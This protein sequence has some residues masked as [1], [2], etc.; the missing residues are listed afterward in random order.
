MTSLVAGCMACELVS[1]R[2][3]QPGGTI[4]EDA[5]WHVDTA[6]SANVW[7]GFLMIK[8]K[9]H[10]VH[11]AELTAPEAASLGSVI[12]VTNRA[13]MEVLQP[14]K[15]YVCSFGDGNAHIHLWVL[16]RPA[17]MKAG[18]HPVIFNL[19]MRIF[20]TRVLHLKKWLV[21]EARLAQIAEAVRAGIGKMD[22]P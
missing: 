19:D 16:P 18:M 15:I 14:A 9:R 2:S 5:H 17:G 11:L 12:R 22:R 10:C 21:P 4:F 8:L 7:P 3:V 1:G 20:L 13:L 6:K